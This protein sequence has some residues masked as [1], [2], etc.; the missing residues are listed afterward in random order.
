MYSRN[1][2]LREMLQDIRPYLPAATIVTLA[3]GALYTFADAPAWTLHLTVA[4]AVLVCMP[5]MLRWS[6]RDTQT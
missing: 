6:G 4:L 2:M 3:G 5:G 1:A